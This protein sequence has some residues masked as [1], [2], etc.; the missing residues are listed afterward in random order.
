MASQ[1]AFYPKMAYNNTYDI[2]AITQ[3]EFVGSER[4]LTKAGGCLDTSLECRRLAEEFD[5]ENLGISVKVNQA[6][7]LADIVC[8]EDLLVPLY[9][10]GV[11]THQHMFCG[12]RVIRLTMKSKRNPFDITQQYTTT[13]PPPFLVGFFNQHWVQA[14]L[15]VPVNFTVSSN[16][17]TN[18]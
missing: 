18:G 2:Q 3:S 16:A 10:T 11:S 15:G 1:G 5:P 13:W 17:V 8:Y 12:H 7:E 9:K 14:D 6:C 4:N